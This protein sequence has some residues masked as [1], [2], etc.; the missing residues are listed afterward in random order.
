MQ[1]L[2]RVA[3][4]RTVPVEV[5]DTYLSKQ[6]RQEMMTFSEFISR[7]IETAQSEKQSCS[8]PGPKWTHDEQQQQ[9][10]QQQQQE[11]V[12]TAYLA[13]HPLFDQ[14]PRLRDD[15]VIPL[16]CYLTE[17]SDGGDAEPAI[18]GWFGK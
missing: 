9:Q 15:I 7:H 13:Q 17:R 3:G 4:M 12:D 11:R 2:K 6:W 8:P 5:G 1:Y 16:Y 14:I 18:N 10:Q